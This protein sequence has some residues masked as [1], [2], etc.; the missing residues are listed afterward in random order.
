M[1]REDK[2]EVFM[3][4]G[5]TPTFDNRESMNNSLMVLQCIIEELEEFHEAAGNY[6]VEQNEDN[7]AQL[8]KEWADLQYVVSQAAVYYDIP[9]DAVFD[10]VHENNLT[11]IP[12]DGII[13]KREDGKILKPE[14]Y[15]KLTTEDMKGF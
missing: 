3:K 14:N 15:Q 4:A 12:E 6:E 13:K 5:Q 8:V 7:R 11:K 9:A 2:V 10:T 1:T